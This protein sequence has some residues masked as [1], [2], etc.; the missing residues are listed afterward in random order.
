MVIVGLT[1]CSKATATAQPTAQPTARPPALTEAAPDPAAETARHATI[2]RDRAA[3]AVECDRA[4]GGD[5]ARWQEQTAGYR[6]ALKKRIEL[7]R[8]VTRSR[9]E[10]LPALDAPMWSGD[11]P[12]DLLGHVYEPARW[13]SARRSGTLPAASRWFRR[14]GIDLIFLPVP[15]MPAMY[16]EHFISTCPADGVIAPHLRQ[17]LLEWLRADVEVVDTWNLM[18]GARGG[19]FQYLPADHH[20]SEAGMIGAVRDVAR[21]LERYQFGRDAKARPPVT[22]SKP[23][24]YEMPSDFDDENGAPIPW[25][26][27]GFMSITD[28]NRQA[29]ADAWPPSMSVITAPDGSKLKSDPEC[30]VLVIGDSFCGHFAHL[31]MREANLLIRVGS[32]PAQD[33]AAFGD[34]LREPQRLHGVKVVLWVASDA[35]MRQWPSLPAPIMAAAGQ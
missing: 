28:E 34:F 20:W 30:P 2:A 26:P 9:L 12:Q 23:G 7:L 10:L 22:A 16:I 8:P 33:T 25:R 17:T 31:L 1:G 18:R 21:R 5:W 13:E 11:R 15:Q 35:R 3:L 29:I 32:S 19:D 6:A 4:A 14:Q 24:P 27:N